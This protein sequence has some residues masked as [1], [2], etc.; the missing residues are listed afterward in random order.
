MAT[1]HLSSGATID[2]D[3]SAD[4][5][6]ELFISDKGSLRQALVPIGPKGKSVRINP[7]QIT[8]ISED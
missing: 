7:R 1:I 8:F 3:A 5:L 6:E 4:K 2:T